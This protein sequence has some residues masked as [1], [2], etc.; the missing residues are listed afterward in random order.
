MRPSSSTL[1]LS[2]THRPHGL[3]WK[4][5]NSIKY[6]LTALNDFSSLSLCLTNSTAIAIRYTD[7]PCCCPYRSFEKSDAQHGLSSSKGLPDMEASSTGQ[8]LPKP[9][10][11]RTGEIYSAWTVHEYCGDSQYRCVCACGGERVQQIEARELL[12]NL[13]F[14]LSLST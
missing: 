12:S 4:A 6:L 7:N 2:S 14:K 11:N 8:C 1:L 5:Q 13:E 10:V 3:H 9:R